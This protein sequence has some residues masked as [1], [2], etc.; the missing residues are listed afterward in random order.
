M[1]DE[2]QQGC[3]HTDY[4]AIL[5]DWD[6]RCNEILDLKDRQIIVNN[7]RALNGQDDGGGIPLLKKIVD[8]YAFDAVPKPI[9]KLHKDATDVRHNGRVLLALRS[10]ALIISKGQHGEYSGWWANCGKLVVTKDMP[11][12]LKDKVANMDS[13]K[14]A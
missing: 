1:M 10:A 12:W 14:N 7:I 11:K 13:A 9:A 3:S 5:A 4:K 2:L 6:A 8:F